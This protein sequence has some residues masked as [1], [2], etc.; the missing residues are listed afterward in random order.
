MEDVLQA[1]F[2]EVNSRGGIFNRKIELRVLNGN[3]GATVTNM[4][5]LIDDSQVFAIVSGLT[6]GAENGVATLSRER[7]VPFIG[8]STLLPDRAS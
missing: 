8:P 1:Y 7:E 5:Q 4:K 6:A 3:A 2:A